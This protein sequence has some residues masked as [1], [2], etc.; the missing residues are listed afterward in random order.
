TPTAVASSYAQYRSARGDL[1]FWHFWGSPVRRNA[2]RRI[3]EAFKLQYP[4]TRVSETFVPYGDIWTKS[5]AAVAA[6]IAMPD[7]LVEERTRRKER[8]KTNVDVSL[9]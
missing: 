6:V 3:V 9:T 4:N 2:I 7:V 8:A 1:T 5:Q